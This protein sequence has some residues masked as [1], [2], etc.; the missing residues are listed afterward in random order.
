MKT[1]KVETRL[2]MVEKEMKASEKFLDKTRRD[3]M[4]E[5]EALKVEV[6]TLRLFIERRHPVVKDELDK[7]R[8]EIIEEMGAPSKRRAA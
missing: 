5:V 2:D 8:K 7:V 6:A 1:E 3:L 4:A